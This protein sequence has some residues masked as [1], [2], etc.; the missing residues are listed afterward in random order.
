MTTFLEEFTLESSIKS[1]LVIKQDVF[2]MK[3]KQ[4]GY[5]WFGGKGFKTFFTTNFGSD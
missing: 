5:F 3:I 4:C 1:I 2:P